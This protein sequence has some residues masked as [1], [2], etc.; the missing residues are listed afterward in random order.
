[1]IRKHIPQSLQMYVASRAKNEIYTSKI[2]APFYFSIC[3]KNIFLT[4]RCKIK[5]DKIMLY[6]LKRI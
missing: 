2:C 5:M 3:Y 6:N 4:S 1:M